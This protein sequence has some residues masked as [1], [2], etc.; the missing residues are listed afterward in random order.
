MV[1][2]TI[3]RLGLVLMTAATVAACGSS[4]YNAGTSSSS[5]G[6]GSS[7]GDDGGSTTSTGFT[8]SGGLST[9]T[10][11]SV[12][13][14]KSVSGTATHIM[15]VT[16]TVGGTTCKQ[17][18]I[19]SNGKFSIELTGLKP[20]L[21]YFYDKTRSG[22]NMFL[23]RIHSSVW[24][25]FLPGSS[26][27]SADLGTLTI[28]AATGKASSSKSHSDILSA[29][30]VTSAMGSFIGKLDDAIRRYSNPD[31]DGDGEVDCSSSKNKFMM[32][33]HVRFD[34]KNSGTSATIADI[35][36]SYLPDTVTATYTGTGIYIAYPSSYSSAT[37][38]TVTFQDTDVTTSEA[39]TLSKGTATSAVT[40]N[41]FSGYY[42][43]GP[44]TTSTSELPTGTIVFTF[45]GKTLT[46]TDVQAPTLADL[47]APTGRIF[48]FIKFVKSNSSCT[49]SC[50]IASMGYKWMKKTE[51]GWTEASTDE[52]S[53]LVAGDGGNAGIR[54]YTDTNTSQIISIKIPITAA[55]GSISWKAANVNLEGVTEAQFN[56]LTTSEI[57]H[58]GLSYDDKIGM[59]YFEGIYNASGTCS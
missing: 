12:S 30:G 8:V 55:S 10:V 48:P 25:A 33:F 23:G 54:A 35:I 44:N 41:N 18:T 22:S 3:L 16:P 27:G 50:T 57:C 9:T 34:M 21:L 52:L 42:G 13:K 40:T 20:W 53:V 58:L 56:A 2:M 47:T 43:F 14:G 15:A 1:L 6:S 59:R 19:D 24:D 11:A 4:G 45:G 36:D 7:G 39:G 17:G 5:G 32:D 26:T 28:D 31:M 49:S 29:F 37:T 51:S 46:Y 38:G